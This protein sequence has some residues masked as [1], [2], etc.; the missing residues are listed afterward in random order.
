MVVLRYTLITS[1]LPVRWRRRFIMSRAH[2]IVLRLRSVVA[3]NGD[4]ERDGR[5]ETLCY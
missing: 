3:I 1:G 2:D 4:E 5:D